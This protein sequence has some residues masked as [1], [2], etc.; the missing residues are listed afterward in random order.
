MVVSG[1]RRCSAT[2]DA[3]PE[4]LLPSAEFLDQLASGVAA[5]SPH[6]F[7]VGNPGVQ[8]S[9]LFVTLEALMAA[10]GFDEA[11]PSCTDRDLMIRLLE[12]PWLRIAASPT[13]T[14]KHHVDPSM[15]RLSNPGEI[16]S[17]PSPILLM[18]LQSVRSLQHQDAVE[19]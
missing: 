2:D 8:G 16:T 4:E 11:L 15:Q 7:L 1:L 3:A 9:N 10:G 6:D 14:V 5:L 18:R 12:L 13:H 19:V 17:P